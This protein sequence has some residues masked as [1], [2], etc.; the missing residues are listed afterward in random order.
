L[1]LATQNESALDR[2]VTTGEIS[3]PGLVLAGYT[4]RFTPARIQVLGATEVAYIDS[5]APDDQRRAVE[6][7]FSFDLPLIVISKGQELPPIVLDVAERVGTPVVISDLG[8]AEFYKR[9]KRMRPR[10][11]RAGTPTRG[12]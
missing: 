5:L 12:G 7:L 2:E 9:Q 10:S 4:E 11:G 1:R 3:S 8:T 6:T